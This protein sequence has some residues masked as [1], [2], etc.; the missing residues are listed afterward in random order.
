MTASAP[1]SSAIRDK[2][3]AAADPVWLVPTMT[4]MRLLTVA[5]ADLI[6][7]SRS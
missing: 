7:A 5:T 4:G 3:A 2:W 6:N 1:R